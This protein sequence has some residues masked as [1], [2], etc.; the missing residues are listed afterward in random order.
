MSDE[1]SALTLTSAERLILANQF[2]ILAALFPNRRAEYIA[3]QRLVEA[4]AAVTYAALRPHDSGLPLD[5][6]H[7]S[8]AVA[9]R[10]K[11]RIDRGGA[12]TPW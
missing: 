10:S 2:A 3:K 1:L 12:L 11:T 6:A 4:D 7:P 5:G 8:N 9:R